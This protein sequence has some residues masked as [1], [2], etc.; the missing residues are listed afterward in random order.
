M[1][2]PRKQKGS[3][4]GCW[5]DSRGRVVAVQGGYLN[6]T[7]KSPVGIAF[8]SPP[9]AIARLIAKK[10]APAAATLGAACDELWT[11]SEG[12]IARLPK[13]TRGI[14]TPSLMKNGPL[15]KAGMTKET[16]ILAIDGKPVQ[17]LDQL[18]RIV[19][20]KKPGDEVTLKVIE[21]IGKPARVVKLRLG[22]IQ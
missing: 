9:D 7:D 15:A 8:V 2:Q 1:C 4:G 10:T 3:S 18:L 20:S 16:V 5:V 12:F 17:Y 6:N 13:G 21:P 11:Q 22:K 19:R 14:V